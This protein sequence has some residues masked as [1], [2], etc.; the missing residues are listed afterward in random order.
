MRYR[1]V[2]ADE[3]RAVTRVHVVAAMP[4]ERIDSSL[5]DALHVIFK[6]KWL[7]IL[8]FITTTS[9]A[10][11]LS[12][13][14]NK[15]VYQASAQILVSPGREHIAD[16]AVPTGGMES[17]ILS[18]NA[19]EQISR[20]IELLTGRF[21]AEHVVKS[22]GA[23]TLYP[24]L[25]ERPLDVLS[26]LDGPVQTEVAIGRFMKN[27]SAQPAGRSSLVN[28]TFNHDE[29]VMAAKAVNLLADMYLDRYLG[30]Q[31]NPRTN[32]FFEEQ[33]QNLKQKLKDSEDKLETFKR[34]YNVG[35]SVK[36]EQER[37]LNQEVTLRTG[38]NETRSHQA[39]IESRIQQLRYQL[40]NTS[41]N[42]GA[43]SAMQE[44]LASLEIQENELALRL[45]A[46]NPT[47]RNVREEIRVLREKLVSLEATSGYG[48]SSSRDGSLYA[49]LQEEILR[50]EAEQK[51]LHAREESQATKQ[52]EIQQR[53]SGLEGISTEFNHLQQQ[54]KLNEESY[55][56]YLAKFEESRISKA[57]DAE[58]IASVRVI[59]PAQPP[60]NPL[61]SKLLIK[62]LGGLFFGALGALGLPFLLRFISGRLSTVDDVERYLELP[63]LASIPELNQN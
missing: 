59:E 29:P 11:T 27:V 61:K 55:R 28:V 34:T 48:S 43:V 9:I 51:A 60:L 49:H 25:S 56:L 2:G 41:R 45:T 47:L 20:T 30:V 22:I 7:V 12:L 15:P 53:L 24:D 16:M 8:F 5:R 18:Y 38:L 23:T 58:R 14:L 57:M 19:E 33:F 39:E 4:F 63:V 1:R 46:E 42:P 6:Q 13:L 21:L 52:R 44:K 37:M 54:L 17:P 3:E 10:T 40:T 31:K 50:N 26:P 35:P 32:A 36:E 62:I